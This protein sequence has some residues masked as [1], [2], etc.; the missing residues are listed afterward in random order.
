MLE[1]KNLQIRGVAHIQR[2]NDFGH[3]LQVVGVVG[4]HERVVARIHVDRVVGADQGAQHG[5][6]IVGILMIQAKNLR[7]DLISPGAHFARTHRTT[8]QLGL[9]LGHDLVNPSGLHHGKA[10]QAQCG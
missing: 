9:G 7:E 4:D 1:W 10:L 6:E 2:S 5:D 3:A 8:L